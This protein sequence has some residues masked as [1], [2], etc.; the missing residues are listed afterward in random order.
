M[1]YEADTLTRLGD[2]HHATGDTDAARSA[3]RYAL[4]ILNNLGHPNADTVR[5]KLDHIE[6]TAAKPIDPART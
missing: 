2:T 4:T 3:W 1:A 5:A 6:P